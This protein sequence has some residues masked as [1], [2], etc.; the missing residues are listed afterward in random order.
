MVIPIV[1]QV[2]TRSSDVSTLPAM[3]QKTELLQI[4]EVQF[5]NDLAEEKER[6][7]RRIRSKSAAEHGGW[8]PI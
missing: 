2:T 7:E 6:A 4:M 3:G 5:H 8:L 1:V